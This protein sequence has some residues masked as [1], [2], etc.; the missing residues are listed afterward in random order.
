MRV[1][2]S[3]LKF[4]IVLRG[5]VRS[6]DSSCPIY[7]PSLR[8]N[9]SQCVFL[10]LCMSEALCCLQAL[11]QSNLWVA[12]FVMAVGSFCL[13]LPPISPI[14]LMSSLSL[15]HSTFFLPLSLFLSDY[16]VPCR[17]VLACGSGVDLPARTA[18]TVC[19]HI[20]VAFC[21]NHS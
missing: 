17:C 21:A 12:M 14:S 20:D 5:A 6:Q 4:C 9:I 7:V 10:Y 1:C 13:F 3:M 16:N 2:V 15:T 19:C 18:C 11:A 8:V